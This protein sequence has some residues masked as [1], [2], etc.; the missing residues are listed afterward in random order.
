MPAKI[1]VKTVRARDHARNQ[2][3]RRSDKG[4]MAVPVTY[5]TRN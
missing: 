4:G 3:T 5:L 2:K 1:S